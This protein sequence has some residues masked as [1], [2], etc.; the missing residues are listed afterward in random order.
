MI[1]ISGFNTIALNYEKLGINTQKYKILAFYKGKK[2]TSRKD[3][4]YFFEKDDPTIA[5]NMLYVETIEYISWLH[6]KTQLKKR[7]PNYFF[8][9]SM[10]KRM[11]LPFSNETVYIIKSWWWFFWFELSL[12]V[13]NNT[14]LESHEKV[15]E[16]KTFCGV[17][18]PSECYKILE[19]SEYWKSDKK[20][21]IIYEGLKS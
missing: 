7:N 13:H 14:K 1:M 2:Y 9:D 6:L 8:N 17:V 10:Q 12:F 3:D 5:L 18:M 4:Q 20:P 11:S 16:N 15:Y 19:F 21:S